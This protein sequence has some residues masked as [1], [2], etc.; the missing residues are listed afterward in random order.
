MMKFLHIAFVALAMLGGA[1]KIS[2]IEVERGWV[3]LYDETGKKYKS[4]NAN[5]VGEIQGYS[6]TFFVSRNGAWIHLYDAE[7]KKYKDLNANTVGTVLSVAGDTFTSRNGAWIF[8]WDKE[9]K[10]ISQRAAHSF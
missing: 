6:S 10:K 3:N 5:T 9:G 2:S 4:L 7:G 1:H 8:T